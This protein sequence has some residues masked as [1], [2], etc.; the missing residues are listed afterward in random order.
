ML[1]SSIIL[2]TSSLIEYFFLQI[3]DYKGAIIIGAISY[4]KTYVNGLPPTGRGENPVPG[5]GPC[6]TFRKTRK[7]K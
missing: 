6:Y 2:I 4:R 5:R 1:Y 7:R 3:A